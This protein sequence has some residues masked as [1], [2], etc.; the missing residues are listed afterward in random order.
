MMKRVA[1]V[2]VEKPKLFL[3]PTVL[4]TIACLVTTLLR[5]SINA[6]VAS[7]MKEGSKVGEEYAA[8]EEKYATQDPIQMLATLPEGKT[9]DSVECLVHMVE[10]MKFVSNIEG[11]STVSSFLPVT[12]PSY[13]DTA[14]AQS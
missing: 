3:A 4:V 1:Q 10:F 14:L 11:I 2:L 8:L 5:F 6:D 9:Y 7:F 13:E 12:D